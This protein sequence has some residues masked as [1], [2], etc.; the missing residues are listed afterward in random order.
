MCLLA[1]K[2]PKKFWLSGKNGLQNRLNKI[3]KRE[4]KKD[5][6]YFDKVIFSDEYKLR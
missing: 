1:H 3:M 4:L 6:A 2:W 5:S